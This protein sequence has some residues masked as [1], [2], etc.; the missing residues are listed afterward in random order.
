MDVEQ[1]RR[2][3]ING[4]RITAVSPLRLTLPI[5]ASGYADAQI[6]DY[7]NGRSRRH[8]SWRPGLEM[9][10]QARFSHNADQLMGTAGFGFWNAPFGDPTIPLPAFPQATWFF[11]ASPPSNLPLAP[12]S[13]GQGWFASTLDA[14]TWKAWSMAPLAPIVLLLNQIQTLRRFIWP[15]VQQGLGI[16][17]M[18]ITTD[19][20]Q[21]HEYKLSWQPHGCTFYVDSDCVLQT[22]HSPRGPLGFVCW[23]DNQYMVAT[24]NGRFRAGTLPISTR[25]W[26]EI[27]HLRIIPSF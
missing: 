9:S 4:G 10:L 22:T 1:L 25:Q 21:W 24:S 2:L 23:L 14:T 19:I 26:L 6:D 12:H 13:P 7:G 20:R 15:K 11:Y 16:S 17:F 18:P 3:E 8:Y 27:D 5:I